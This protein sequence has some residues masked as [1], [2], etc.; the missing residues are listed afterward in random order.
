M[1]VITPADY[2]MAA[3]ALDLQAAQFLRWAEQDRHSRRATAIEDYRRN[4]AQAEACKQAAAK[5]R[6]KV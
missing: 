6:S 2:A 3:A 5:F 4:A 1:V